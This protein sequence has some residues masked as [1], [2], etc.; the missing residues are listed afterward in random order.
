ML[1]AAGIAFKCSGCD[2]YGEA[3]G[4]SLPLPAQVEAALAWTLREGVTN[5]IRHSRA[6]HCQIEL[7]RSSSSVRLGITDD[8]TPASNGKRPGVSSPRSG[9]SNEAEQAGWADRADRA[10]SGLAGL[11]ERVQALQGSYEAGPLATG[12][13]RL[14]VTLPLSA[15]KEVASEPLHVETDGGRANDTHNAG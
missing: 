8:G 14:S 4:G 15:G 1:S 5:V 2:L 11:R 10:G 13:F 6:R 7:S 12:G 9:S 3:A